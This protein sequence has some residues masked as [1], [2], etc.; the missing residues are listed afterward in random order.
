M[1]PLLPSKPDRCFPH[2]HVALINDDYAHFPL[3]KSV[4]REKISFFEGLN[5]QSVSASRSTVPPLFAIRSLSIAKRTAALSSGV[6]PFTCKNMF[7]FAKHSDNLITDTTAYV[8]EKERALCYSI[9]WPDEKFRKKVMRERI[10]IPSS[11]A[12]FA[13]MNWVSKR[14]RSFELEKKRKEKQQLIANEVADKRRKFLYRLK[15]YGE[16][17]LRSMFP[18]LDQQTIVEVE[19]LQ[20]YKCSSCDKLIYVVDGLCIHNKCSVVTL[21]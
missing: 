19:K 12:E 3:Q 14:K 15:E 1:R 2:E 13:N 7:A 4:D 6:L 17:E 9:L 5:L 10:V 20:Q 8:L 11:D 16:K 21:S 18:K